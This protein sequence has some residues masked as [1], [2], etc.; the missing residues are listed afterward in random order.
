MFTGDQLPIWSRGTPDDMAHFGAGAWV[1]R[2]GDYDTGE[3]L[4][5]G[6][7]VDGDQYY[8]K[9]TNAT[10][11]WIDYHL[12]PGDIT[13]I[14][15]GDPD[16]SKARAAKAV[17]QPPIVATGKDIGAPLLAAKGSNTGKLPANSERWFSFTTPGITGKGYEFKSYLME[18]SHRP[19][20][21][22][23]ANHVNVEIYPYQQQA[24]WRRGDGDQ[25]TPL[26]A[27]SFTE[28]NQASDSH[29]W[30]WDGHLVSS[31]TYFIKVRNGS[32]QEVDYDLR[33][34][35]K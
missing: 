14:E 1:S 2:D 5:H 33:I 11:K 17:P 12:V 8:V 3:R 31:T 22:S 32:A 6:T 10:G 35:P 26:G 29:T 13:N 25:M 28:Y 16:G 23:V 20:F 30:V 7:V 34:R 9:L 27:G 21:G 4:W 24:L 18:L 19:G 15:M